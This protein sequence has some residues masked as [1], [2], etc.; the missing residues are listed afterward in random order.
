MVFISCRLLRFSEQRDVPAVRF[1]LYAGVR[2]LLICSARVSARCG[3]V[4]L[5]ACRHVVAVAQCN[6]PQGFTESDDDELESL[7][8][9]TSSES[10]RDEST[11]AGSAA[12][13]DEE[14]DKKRKPKGRRALRSNKGER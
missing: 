8:E 2:S 7:L 10:E 6:S 3:S 9:V 4:G 11:T 1:W 5:L 14:T 13:S 12:E